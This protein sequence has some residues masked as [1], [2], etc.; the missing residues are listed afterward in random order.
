LIFSGD[1]L[2]RGDTLNTNQVYLTG[3]LVDLGLLV[4][5][6]LCV[7]DDLSVMCRAIDDSLAR[8]PALLVLSG[9]LGPTEDDLTREAV[10]AS[11]GLSLEQHQGLLDA[12]R[13]RFDSRGL[14]MSETNKKQALLPAGATPLPFSGTAPGFAL[15]HDHTMLVAL[16][17]VPW[18]LKDMW[19]HQ[20]E[21][22]VRT[23]TKA[24]PYEV[25]RLRTFGLG[26]STV[27]QNLAEIDW[28]DPEAT[29]GTRAD[30]DGI[31]L[32]LRGIASP[33]GIHKL[34][35]L[36]DRITALLGDHVYSM[37]GETLSTAVGGLLRATGLTVAAAESCT[38]GL[39]GKLLTDVSGSSS[40]F[41]G[42][43]IA[44]DNQV[45]SGVLGVP[46]EVL[47]ARGAVSNEAAAA[48]AQGVCRLTGASCGLSTTGIAGPDGGSDDKPVGL[49]YLGCAV[50]DTTVTKR[51]NLFGGRDQ[52][53][54]RAAF[55]ALDLLRRR[56]QERVS[57]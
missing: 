51:L 28:H 18:E 22:L 6:A 35:A 56:L 43:V 55:S 15:Q 16:P 54:G 40:Y 25:R 44:Y 20:A 10:A 1:E 32:I 26:E 48:M 50:E 33:G 23:H 37:S 19:E 11:L 2:L 8:K 4:T 29:I 46:D 7:T 42:G 17:G 53:R 36:Q 12:I 41:L 9:G 13:E 31:T 24:T 47:A 27:A 45:K 14:H 21:P 38:G 52:I 3:R 34:D 49:V 30:L 57:T 5:H 39:L